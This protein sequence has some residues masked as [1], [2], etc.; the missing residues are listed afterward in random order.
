MN[1]THKDM[2]NAR[3]VAATSLRMSVRG[4]EWLDVAV[5]KANARADDILQRADATRGAGDAE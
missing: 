3:R 1:M 5:A 4:D 2:C